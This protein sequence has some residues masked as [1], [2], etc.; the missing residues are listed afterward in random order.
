MSRDDVFYE[1]TFPFTKVQDD[2]SKRS[3]ILPLIHT[4]NSFEYD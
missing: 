4:D 3:N 2:S 1:K